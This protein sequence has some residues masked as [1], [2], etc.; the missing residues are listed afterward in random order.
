MSVT[1]H[2]AYVAFTGTSPSSP[3]R[4]SPKPKRRKMVIE[5]DDGDDGP[6][7]SP[8]E[9]CFVRSFFVFDVGVNVHCRGTIA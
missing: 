7:P 8:R 5:D 1:L 4:H 6:A 2:R 3:E 9:L